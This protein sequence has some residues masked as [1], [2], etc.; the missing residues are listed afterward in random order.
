MNT[1]KRILGLLILTVNM[2]CLNA[3]DLTVLPIE[4]QKDGQTEI[5]VSLNGATAMTALQFN[6][7]LPNGVTASTDNITLGAA[8]DG[9]T[10]SVQTHESGDLLFI[11]YS[12]NFKVFKGGVL[13]RIPVT[14]GNSEAYATGLLYNVRAASADAVSHQCSN[15]SF[16]VN[17]TSTAITG[18]VNSDG[19]VDIV[20]V[21]LLVNHLLGGE[22]PADFNAAAADI[23]GI[24]GV[25][26]NDLNALINIVL[27]K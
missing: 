19:T 3:Q 21:T 12:M 17:I 14:A 26:A 7:L 13:L 9:H 18:D 6:L 16:P 23:D 11:L 4:V 2:V 10:L 27:K 15:E 8:T 5:V 24:E 22:T 25:D 20:D 1:I